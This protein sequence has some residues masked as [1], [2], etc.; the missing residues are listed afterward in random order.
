MRNRPGMQGI[1][2]SRSRYFLEVAADVIIIIIYIYIIFEAE[3][4]KP[5]I[6][7]ILDSDCQSQPL[8]LSHPTSQFPW[9]GYC[10]KH[11]NVLGGNFQ[12]HHNVGTWTGAVGTR[13]NT[14]S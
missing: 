11:C 9:G 12:S 8:W 3:H 14:C 5:K 2:I 10:C 7:T 13:R 6:L 4:G 1:Q